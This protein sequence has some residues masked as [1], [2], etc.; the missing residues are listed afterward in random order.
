MAN[1]RLNLTYNDYAAEGSQVSFR[2]REMTAATFDGL[3][4][5]EDALVVAVEAATLCLL[6][7]DLRIATESTPAAGGASSPQA[8]RELKWLVRMYDVETGRAVSVQIPG[9][10]TSLLEAGSDRMDPASAE[11]AAL[12]AAIEA[13]HRSVEDNSV[14]VID[15]VLVGRNL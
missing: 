10:D 2:G 7:K 4:A 6:V 9:A 3:M 12:V 13:F 14:A 8:Q 5:E 1:S 15:I 11:Y